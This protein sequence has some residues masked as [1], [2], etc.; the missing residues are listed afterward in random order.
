[1][2]EDGPI[3]D[4]SGSSAFGADAETE[5]ADAQRDKYRVAHRRALSRY[6]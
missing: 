3:P 1:M 4:L 2:G 5:L 6:G